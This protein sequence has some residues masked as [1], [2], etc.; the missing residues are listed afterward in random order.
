MASDTIQLDFPS[1]GAT[2]NLMMSAIFLKGT[3]KLI[4]VAKEPEI[5]DL[6][7]FLNSM[8][9]DVSGAGTA[10]ITIIRKSAFFNNFAD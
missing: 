8:G 6:Q 4:N 10:E 1:V 2:E 5:V 9:A 7:N 3:T